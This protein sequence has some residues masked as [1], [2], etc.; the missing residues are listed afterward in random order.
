[1]TFTRQS[2]ALTSSDVERINLKVST[3]VR[4][5]QLCFYRQQIKHER[6]QFAKY[7]VLAASWQPCQ[8]QFTCEIDDPD[9]R[10]RSRGYKCKKWFLTALFSQS[11]YHRISPLTNLKELEDLLEYIF[12]K[13]SSCLA[14][15]SGELTLI[16]QKLTLMSTYTKVVYMM[17]YQLCKICCSVLS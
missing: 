11:I 12:F 7:W 5:N 8:Q 17:G 10:C 2:F 16:R 4:Y 1:M 9:S 3:N 13:E 6:Q 15:V 14:I